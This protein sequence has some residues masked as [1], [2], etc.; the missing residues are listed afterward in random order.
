MIIIIFN[1]MHDYR[2]AMIAS[3]FIT[4]P[5]PESVKGPLVILEDHLW[6]L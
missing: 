4:S 1:G 3:N 2:E 5:L 6:K